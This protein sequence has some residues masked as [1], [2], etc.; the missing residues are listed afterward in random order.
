MESSSNKDG[1]DTNSNKIKNK[2]YPMK[3]HIDVIEENLKDSY[4][5]NINYVKITYDDVLSD[6]N[7]LFSCGHAFNKKNFEKELVRE[8]GRETIESVVYLKI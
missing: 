8:E 4:D 3:S 5:F 2:N 6:R 7:Y 1:R